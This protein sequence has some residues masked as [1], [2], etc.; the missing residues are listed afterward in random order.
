MFLVHIR[1]LSIAAFTS[2]VISIDIQKCYNECKLK[3]CKVAGFYQILRKKRSTLESDSEPILLPSILWNY[4]ALERHSRFRFNWYRWSQQHEKSSIQAPSSFEIANL[5]ATMVLLKKK[6]VRK[7]SARNINFSSIPYFL[8]QR[9]RGE[10]QPSSFR[11]GVYLGGGARFTKEAAW[12]E[13]RGEG[14][15]GAQRGWLD[16]WA[17][18]YDDKL[19]R[20]LADVRAICARVGRD[21]AEPIDRF[22][23]IYVVLSHLFERYTRVLLFSFFFFCASLACISVPR[24]RVWTNALILGIG[25]PRRD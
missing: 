1:P 6:N 18:S 5:Y 23:C 11:G 8:S 9:G 14:R 12:Q 22:S 15:E 7:K 24:S 16:R 13:K 2:R 25:D 3:N 21:N 20:L 19:A 10:K 17:T 4:E